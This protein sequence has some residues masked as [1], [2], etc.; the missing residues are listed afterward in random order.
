VCQPVGLF[1]VEEW[2]EPAGD[3]PRPEGKAGEEAELPEAP[4][5]EVL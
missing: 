4:D 3:Q 2:L 1:A 5:F